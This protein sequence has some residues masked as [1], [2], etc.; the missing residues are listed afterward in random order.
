M[1]TRTTNTAPIELTPREQAFIREVTE[2][3]ELS[4]YPL[5]L[6]SVREVAN[7]TKTPRETIQ[8]WIESG[9]IR[10]WDICGSPRLRRVSLSEVRAARLGTSKASQGLVLKSEL[11]AHADFENPAGLSFVPN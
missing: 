5:D 8:M 7:I 4:G 11:Q 9:T 10:A 6:L 2:E 3:H 1:R